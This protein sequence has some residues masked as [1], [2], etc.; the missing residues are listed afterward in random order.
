MLEEIQEALS[1]VGLDVYYG[2]A[3][4]M[5]GED[6]WDYIVLYRT[7]MQ[8]PRNKRGMAEGFEVAVVCEE[9]V[10]TET[11]SG[12]LTAMLAIPGM[13]LADTGGTF[14]YTRKPNTEQV[15]EIV[16]IDFVRPARWCPNV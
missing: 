3:G 9:F 7:S 15:V 12:V 14:N 5:S 10:P 6:V 11:I 4:T 2:A 16:T 8:P 1:S 13:R